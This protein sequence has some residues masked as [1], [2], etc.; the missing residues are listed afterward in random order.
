MTMR[1]PDGNLEHFKTRDKNEN[2]FQQVKV[3]R[4]VIPITGR[5][6]Q[7]GCETSRLPHF[8]DSQ[9]KAGGEAVT[10]T[11]RTAFTSPQED[12]WCSFVLE[13]ESTPGP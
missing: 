3:K 2:L 4:K 10:L 9:L 13:D 7:Y 11:R 8:L 12:S 5:E 6:G 1:V